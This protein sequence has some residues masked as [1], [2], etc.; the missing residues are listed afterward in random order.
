VK[1]IVN[2]LLGVVTSIGG[3]VEVGS[4]STAA[5]A[6]AEFGFSLLW[7]ILAAT[8][9]LAVVAEMAGRMAAV[10]KRPVAA[11]VRER[12]GFHFQIVPL[13]AELIIDLLL[14]TAEIGGAAT[15][16]KLLTG[17]GFQWW[18][19]PIGLIVWLVLW[20]GNFSLIEDGVGLLGMVTLAFVVSAW[21][22]QPD[23]AALSRGFLPALPGHDLTRYAFLAVSIVGA[24]LSPYL[25]NF[26]AS[27]AIEERWT[28]SDLW[29]N[30]TTAF[31]G[32]GFGSVVSMGVL[33]TSA[34]VLGPQHVRVESYE[35]AAQMFVPV[36]GRWAVMLFALSLGIGCFGAATEIA[37]NA[38]YL[39]A[40]SFGWSWGID[41]K[42]GDTARFTVAFTGVLLL[43]IGIAVLGFDPLKVTLISAALTV[44]IMPLVV[45]PF[46]VLMNDETYVKTHGS[47]PLG[48]GV[49]A[50][51]TIL[52]ALMAIVVIP[53]QVLGG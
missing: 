48:N 33:V 5:Q 3:F 19:L 50:A 6:G 12:F 27:G 25:L 17:I 47:G 13:S 24:T 9:M 15:A 40:Q 10:S 4:I 16:V 8:V 39:L 43:A 18:V 29:I 41:K 46:L 53:L 38:G 35:Q 34:I 11:A 52:G 22:L 37:L 1:K 36:F 7:A 21:K 42:R 30:K 26:Y 49:L 23:P 14:L 45:L 20:L 2:L 31:A 44:V 28:P 51:L 32:M